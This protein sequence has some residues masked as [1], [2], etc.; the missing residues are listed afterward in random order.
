VFEQINPNPVTL[1][2]TDLKLERLARGRG[3]ELEGGQTADSRQLF[4]ANP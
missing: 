4:E 1:F 3:E 2:Q